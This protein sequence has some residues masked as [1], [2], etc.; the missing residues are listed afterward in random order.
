MGSDTPKYQVV[1][2]N[3]LNPCFNRE[4]SKESVKTTL[5]CCPADARC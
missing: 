4:V 2:L 5:S 3:R 1:H